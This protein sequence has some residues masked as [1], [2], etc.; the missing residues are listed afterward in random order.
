VSIT[1]VDVRTVDETLVAVLLTT[2]FQLFPR[3]RR[4]S[5]ERLLS[6]HELK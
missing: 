2:P 5:D 6:T 1:T 4:V 3:A